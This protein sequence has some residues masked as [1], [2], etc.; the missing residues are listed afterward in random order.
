MQCIQH[1]P[2]KEL[3]WYSSNTIGFDLDVTPHRLKGLAE[4]YDMAE[5]MT[6]EQQQETKQSYQGIVVYRTYRQSENVIVYQ[7]AYQQVHQPLYLQHVLATAFAKFMQ[8]TDIHKRFQYGC[9]KEYNSKSTDTVYYYKNHIKCCVH[10]NA[11]AGFCL[12]TNIDLIVNELK[13]IQNPRS[14]ATTEQI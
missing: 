6:P 5:L 4:H 11:N 7:Q 13:E 12:A 8:T 10:A 3:W 9:G 2:L 14:R 1:D